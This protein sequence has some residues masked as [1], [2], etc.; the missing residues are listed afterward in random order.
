MSPV[1]VSSAFGFGQTDAMRAD[2]VDGA[3]GQW[4]DEVGVYGARVGLRRAGH[5][6]LVAV[7]GVDGRDPP[8][9][10][11]HAGA[12]RIASVTKTFTSALVLDLVDRGDLSFDHTLAQWLPA[13][14]H[15]DD[16]TVRM[17]LHHTAGTTDLL[18]D[19]LDEFVEM[20]LADLGRHYTPRELVALTEARP[21]HSSPGG[22]Y[23]YS[24]TDYNLLGFILEAVADEDFGATLSRRFTTPLGLRATSYDTT[25]A[26]DLA[27]GWFDLTSDG[28]PRPTL[29]RDLDVRAFPNAAIITT[30]F[31]SGGLTS[32]LQDLLTWAEALYLGNALSR[33]MRD[34]LLASPEFDDPSGGG[35]HGLGVFGFG[36]QTADGGWTAYGHTGNTIGSSAFVAAFPGSHSIVACHANVQ[37][38]PADKFVELALELADGD[39]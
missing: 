20:M 28:Q 6:D 12:F 31:A 8:S 17:L 33:S 21:P 9:P 18:F 27:H 13:Y 25:V 23:R 35:R 32:T 36:E 15:A 19:A 37:E 24:N 30:A 39:S 5:R 11:P 38:V 26:D 14:P 22:S 7:W 1:A 10:M 3:L 4:C 34:L 29:A 16:I 2:D